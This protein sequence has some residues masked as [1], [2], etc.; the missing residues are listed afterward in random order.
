MKRKLF[1]FIVFILLLLLSN[2][3][4]AQGETEIVAQSSFLEVILNFVMLLVVCGCLFYTKKI[5]SFL[6]GGELSFGW[7]LIFISFLVLAFVQ[8]LELGNSINVVRLNSGLHFFLK[9][10]WVILLVWGIYRLKKVLS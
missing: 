6:K 9:L 5:E 10:I 4:F 1:F 3:S 8:S 7:F 2:E